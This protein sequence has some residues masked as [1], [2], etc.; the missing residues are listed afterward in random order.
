MPEGEA[1]PPRIIHCDS[2]YGNHHPGSFVPM[3]EA[4]LDESRRRGWAT[5]V[6]LQAEAEGSQSVAP[7]S[8]KPGPLSTSR[9]AEIAPP[10]AAI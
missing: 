2:A 5:E 3:L 8:A 7:T 10:S 9:R 1:A 6:V 4:A